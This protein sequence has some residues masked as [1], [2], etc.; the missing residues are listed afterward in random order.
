MENQKKTFTAHEVVAAGCTLEPIQC[1][2]CDSLEVTFHQY[3]GD[4]HCAYCGDWQINPEG[5]LIK[6]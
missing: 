5:D 2:F 3:L 6:T 4:A 1:I